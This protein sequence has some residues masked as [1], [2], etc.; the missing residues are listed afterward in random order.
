MKSQISAGLL[1]FSGL[2][3]AFLPAP[4][5]NAY[6]MTLSPQCSPVD[7]RQGFSFRMR[8]QGDINWCYAFATADEL[9]YYFKIPEPLSAADVALQY[10][11]GSWPRLMRWLSGKAVHE[12]GFV[13]SA[14][15]AS[16]AA[17]YCPE[18]DFPSD[19]WT[20]RDATGEHPMQLKEAINDLLNL[21]EQVQ[22]G[23]YLKASDLPYTYLFKT[24]SQD[25]LFELLANTSRTQLINQLRLTACEKDRKPFPGT[26][27]RIKMRLK[28]RNAFTHINRVLDTQTPV[29]V[30][31]FYGF[32]DNADAYVH[33][34]NDLHST[35]LVGR[36]FDE[37]SGECQYLIKNSYGP[38][39]SE[40]D[41]RHTCEGG[42]VWVGESDL[43]GAL[44]SYVYV[45][46]PL[47]SDPGPDL[48]S[49][50]ESGLKSRLKPAR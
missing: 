3:T 16:L 39:C 30:D 24:V 28:G 32:L 44:T 29:T 47:T 15:W 48:K 7:L 38:D 37:K 19:T 21:Q 42:Y 1:V 4:S 26:I 50:P 2:L 12:T 49:E 11:E 35:L 36:R 41:P 31:F 20:K 33:S 13:R 40:Y 25:Q 46:D 27:H 43:Y 5:A 34:L 8:N 17:G 9:Q 6:Y 14:M 10:N 23:F 45:M 18:S 22:D